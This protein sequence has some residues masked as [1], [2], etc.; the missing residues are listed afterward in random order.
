MK[1]LIIAIINLIYGTLLLATLTAETVGIMITLTVATVLVIFGI[2]GLV[3]WFKM[4]LQSH[5]DKIP[6]TGPIESWWKMVRA[7]DIILIIGLF[8]RFL[9]VQPF[10]VDGPSMEPN[11]HDKEAILVDK[12]SL[13]IRPPERGEVIIFKA[14]PQP[15]EDYI[16]RIIGLPGETITIEKSNVYINDKLLSEV[17]LSADG[18]MAA[19]E[20]YQKTLTQD[21]YF[22]MGDNRPH[23][24][25]SRNWGAVPKKNLIGRA[26]IVVYPLNIFGTVRNP[27]FSF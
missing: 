21:E 23:S 14:P 27:K 8:F 22:V 1:Y 11:F 15:N 24:S 26:S 6:D 17:Y 19:D 20:Y 16:K 9:I 25:D 7:F 3:L 13:K 10:V 2:W 18:Q 5:Q 4:T 12:I